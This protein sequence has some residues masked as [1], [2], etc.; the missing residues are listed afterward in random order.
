MWELIL[1]QF[2][3]QL[4]IILLGSAVVSFVLA[5]FEEEGGWSAFVDPAVVRK[6][7]SN[8][9]G[10]PHH[11]AL[12]FQ[13]VCRE[14][15]ANMT[16]SR[17]LRFSFSMPLSESLRRAAPKKPSPPYRNTRLTRPM[18]FATMVMSRASRLTISFR[19]ISL[20]WPSVTASLPIAVSSTSRA[21]ASLST[22]L[23]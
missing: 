6:L 12:L 13:S 23:S 8:P 5:L 9:L 22:R 10:L 4:V 15:V 7:W 11:H 3:D 1:E 21:T 2:K 18:S 16:I 17:S 19:V 14:P 20:L